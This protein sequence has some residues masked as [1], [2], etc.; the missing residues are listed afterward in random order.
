[1]K[2]KLKKGLLLTA[3]AAGILY[4]ANRFIDAYSTLKSLL[5]FDHGHFYNWRFGKVFYTKTGTGSPILLIHDLSPAASAYEWNFLVK[6]LAEDHTVYS[7]DLLGCGRSDK[8]NMTYTNYLYVQLVNDFVTKVIKKKTDIAATGLSSSFVIMAANTNSELFDKIIM[9]NPKSAAELASIPNSRSRVVKYILDI[10]ILGTSV[11]HMLTSM[12]NIE[13]LFTE[14]Y[15]YNPFH[16]Q[17]K[18][19]SV[20]YESAHRD[21][22]HGKY[23]MASIDG[24]FVNINI[25]AALKKL[26]NPILLIMGAQYESAKQIAESYE[27]LNSSIETV[28]INETKLLPQLEMPEFTYAHMD[29]FLEP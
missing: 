21:S 23:L 26:E 19:I 3:S 16:I 29:L 20:Y 12:E 15:F 18:L 4:L 2:N 14:K 13:Y 10:P 8:P 25:S 6:R 28:Y 22:S 11:Y 1:M 24:N 9:I 17:Q 5:S 7:L 27:K